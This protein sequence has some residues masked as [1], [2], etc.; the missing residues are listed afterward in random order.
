M[1]Q[2]MKDFMSY[3]D[4]ILDLFVIN[5]TTLEVGD[6]VMKDRFEAINKDFRD[7]FITEVIEI[8]WTKVVDIFWSF[9]FGNE[10]QVGF[11]E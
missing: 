4:I 1:F 9:N 5:E 2:E 7:D 6:V 8:N 11:M 3:K 10:N